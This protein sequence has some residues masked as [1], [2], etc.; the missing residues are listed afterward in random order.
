VT[1][2]V[3]GA[4]RLRP[5]AC[6]YSYIWDASVVLDLFKTWN[7]NNE[8]DLKSLTLKT[9]S[10]LSLCSAQRVQTLASIE[11]HNISFTSS[12]VNIK[13]DSRLKTSRPG[14]G[15]LIS[16]KKFRNKKLCVYDALKIYLERTKD[17]RCESKWFI[18]ILGP[19]RTVSSQTISRWLKTVLETSGV[20]TS[21]FSGHSFRHSATSKASSAGICLDTIYKAAGWS[22]KSKVF[23]R[24]YNK[25]ICKSDFSTSLL[26]C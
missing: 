25:P 12:E 9:V 13:V 23:A 15:F 4:G 3:K 16:L 5:P 6:K 20:D 22:E 26:K 21:I 18:S 19:H 17:I 2:L 1:R 24:F 11:I 8:L 14:K 7:H 10:L